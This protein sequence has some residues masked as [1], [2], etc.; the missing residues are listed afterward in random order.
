MEDIYAEKRALC[1]AGCPMDIVRVKEGRF[2]EGLTGLLFW[3][4]PDFPWDGIKGGSMY[5]QGVSQFLL[6]KKPALS[7]SG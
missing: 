4:L 3:I 6:E 7:G 5:Q 1:S 2:G